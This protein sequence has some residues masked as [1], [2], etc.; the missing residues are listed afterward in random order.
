[1]FLHVGSVEEA[2]AAAEAGVDGIIALGSEAG[3][4]VKSMTALSTFVPAVVEAVQ[5]VPVIAAGGLATTVV[6]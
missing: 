5:P 3:G 4:H 6:S 1:V 2:E